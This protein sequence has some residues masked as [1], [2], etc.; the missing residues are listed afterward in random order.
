MAVFS[1]QRVQ[2]GDLISADLMNRLID[3][4]RSL[5][6]RVTNLEEGDSPTANP[7]LLDR[8]PTGDVEVNSLLT[9]I[10]RNFLIPPQNN[11]VILDGVPIQSFAASDD[12]NLRFTIPDVFST[13]PRT[14]SVFVRNA[15]GDSSQLQIRLLPRPP[16]QGG[17]V[18]VFNQTKPLGKIVIGQTY[19]LAWLVDSQTLLPATYNLTVVLSNVVGAPP[20]LWQSGI[21][22]TPV[23]PIQIAP[24]KP[25]AV[26]AKVTVPAGATSVEIALKAESTDLQFS[27][28]SPVLS[29]TVDA[30]PDVSDPRV[31]LTLDD[32][33]P[34]DS[35]GNPNTV[36]AAT[37]NGINGAEVK[38]GA[39]GQ[40]PVAM[41]VT[42]DPT[43]AG[44]YN[45]TVEI[46]NAAALWSSPG[47]ATP[48]TSG[49]VAPSDKTIQAGVRNTDTG[50]STAVTF[51]VV[52]ALHQTAGG[53][54]DFT[55]F[56][57]IPIR[58]FA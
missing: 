45:Y 11:T 23:G 38:F 47:T 3:A 24:G 15:F 53:V 35:G 44:T 8:S 57:R 25:L 39:S 10:G 29:L 22:L 4:F 17:D 6:T 26:A 28:S 50:N 54:Q 1:F 19:N 46:E 7:V 18:V 31:L 33:P 12:K 16:Q 41:H 13:L 49:Q 30:V 32:I 58:G 9:L 55:S 51:L 52:K 20:N 21:Q 34:L 27:Q 48:A 56:M 40:I 14:V 5:D 43:A 37:I 36:R 2:P 42:A